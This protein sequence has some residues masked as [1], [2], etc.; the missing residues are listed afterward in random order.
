[1]PV[2]ARPLEI[3]TQNAPL[4]SIGSVPESPASTSADWLI[5]SMPINPRSSRCTSAK[6]A[7]YTAVTSANCESTT[8]STATPWP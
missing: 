1:M 5:A 3:Q 7:P 8:S 6:A 2:S 4:S